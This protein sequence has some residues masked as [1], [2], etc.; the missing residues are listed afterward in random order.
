MGKVLTA[1]KVFPLEGQDLNNLLAD[2]KK[3]EGCNKAEVID[4]V[5]GVKVIQASFICEDSSGKDYEEIV[6]QVPGVSEVQVEEVGLI[7]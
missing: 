3:V 4:Y 2:V 7:G 5:F 6:K 1:M